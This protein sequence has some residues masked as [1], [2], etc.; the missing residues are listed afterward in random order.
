MHRF[1]LLFISI[2]S[3]A[4]TSSFAEEAWSLEKDKDGIKVWTR[5][6][7]NSS[8]KE[9][10]AVTVVQ[11]SMD[12]ILSTIKNYKTYEKWMY[13]VDAGS[14]KLVKKTSDNDF[15]V[16][17]TISAPFIKSRESVTH[18]VVSAPDAKGV[19]TISMNAEP[20][21]LPANSDYVRISKMNGYF[22]LVPQPNGKIEI[23]HQAASSP[24][25]SIPDSMANLGVVDAPFTILTKLKSI[26]LG[27]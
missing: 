21:A 25:G 19:V 7:P 16:R 13:K 18:Y 17:M 6:T 24:G 9:Y 10:K 20:N 12:K 3:L 26:I 2:I 27:S 15:I 5:K 22:K 14:V 11:S 8:L 4:H 1:I 23:T